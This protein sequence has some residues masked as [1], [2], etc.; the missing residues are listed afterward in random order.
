MKIILNNREEIV[1]SEQLTV[2]Q[3]LKYK[4]FSFK[5][6]VIKVNGKL[7]KKSEYETTLVND[8]DDVMVLHLISGG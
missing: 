4:N 2:D 5:M 8:G 7:V 6:L 3:L 1:E